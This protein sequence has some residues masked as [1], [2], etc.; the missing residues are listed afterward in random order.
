MNGIA[1][2]VKEMQNGKGVVDLIFNPVTCEFEEMP[3]G[4][5]PAVGDVVNAVAKLGYA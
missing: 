3:C 5:V 1:K 2:T 4:M